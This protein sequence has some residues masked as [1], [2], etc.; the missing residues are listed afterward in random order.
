MFLQGVRAAGELIKV[1]T[2]WSNLEG[3][4][5][6]ITSWACLDKSGLKDIFHLYAQ[7]ETFFRSSLSCSED[8]SVSWT[9]KKMDVSSANSFTVDGKFLRFRGK[10]P[11]KYAFYIWRVNNSLKYKH[12]SE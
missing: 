1:T 11:K 3:F 6:N 7:S 8:K 2:G 9:M 12:S 4:C 10:S 5:E